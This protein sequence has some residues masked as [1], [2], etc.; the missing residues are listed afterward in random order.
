MVC[1]ERTI[2]KQELFRLEMHSLMFRQKNGHFFSKYDCSEPQRLKQTKRI[3][4]IPMAESLKSALL[5]LRHLECPRSRMFFFSLFI[6]KML[7]VVPL[8]DT[9]ESV[10]KI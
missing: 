10:S 1:G 9:I 5:Q 6:L 2:S 8:R 3:E 4:D 7:E